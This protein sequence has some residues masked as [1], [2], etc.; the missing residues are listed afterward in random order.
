AGS[1]VRRLS[2]SSCRRPDR[3]DDLHVPGAAAEIAAERLADILLARPRTPAQQR[4]GGP[5]HPGGAEAA[6][7]T[8]LL[9]E[10]ALQRAQLPVGRLAFYGLDRAAFA[11]RGER[12]AGE[13][14]G[15]ADEDRGGPPP[16]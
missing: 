8:E 5:D 14:R 2:G 12:E 15:P 3:L 4:L 16:A 9:V 6:L 10:G 11:A 1:G 13:A 7:G